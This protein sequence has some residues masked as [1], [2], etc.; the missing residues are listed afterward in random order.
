MVKQ[1]I[2]TGKKEPMISID[3]ARLHPALNKQTA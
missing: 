3:G 1:T 2:Q